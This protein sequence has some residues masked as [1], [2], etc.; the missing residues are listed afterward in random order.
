MISNL[1]KVIAVLTLSL[2]VQLIVYH[3]IPAIEIDLTRNILFTGILNLVSLVVIHKLLRINYHQPEYK[4]VSIV[5]TLIFSVL[6]FTIPRY[7]L[8]FDTYG[9]KPDFDK[10][11]FGLF[12]IKTVIFAPVFE[13]ILFRKILLKELF[14]RNKINIYWAVLLV[15]IIFTGIHLQYIIPVFRSSVLLT[16]FVFSILISILYLK[17]KNILL[18]IFVHGLNNLFSFF[19]SYLFQVL[20]AYTLT[21][22]IALAFLFVLLVPLFFMVCNSVSYR[23]KTV[24]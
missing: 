12:I 22:K 17:T 18:V 9:F 11:V 7:L 3:Y 14:L 4:K 13:E 6:I 16:T 15:A 5:Y 20:S 2:L 21:G 23:G 8:I 19:G 1:L 10:A 24:T